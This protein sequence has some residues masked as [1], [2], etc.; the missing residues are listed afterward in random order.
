MAVRHQI[1]HEKQGYSEVKASGFITAQN[2]DGT[3]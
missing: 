2:N 1:K 3:E